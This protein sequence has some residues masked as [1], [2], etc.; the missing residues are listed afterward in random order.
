MP[1]YR[2]VLRSLLSHNSIECLGFRTDIAEIMRSCDALVL[3]SLSEGSALVCYEAR[4]CGLVLL[5]S[6]ACGAPCV[7]DVDGLVHSPGDVAA[8]SEH[9]RRLANPS[10]LYRLRSA[11][12]SGLQSITW[13]HAAQR[14]EQ[15]YHDVSQRPVPPPVQASYPGYRA[16]AKAIVRAP[17]ITESQFRLDR[18]RRRL[19]G[20]GLQRQVFSIGIFEGSSLLSLVAASGVENPVI[21]PEMVSD[22]DAGLVADPFW[23][24]HRHRWWMFFEVWNNHARKGEIACA[25]STDLREWHYLG[26]VLRDWCHLS[27]PYVFEDSG[28]IFMVP[29]SGMAGEIRLYRATDFPRRWR[30]QKVLLRGPYFDAT[31][32]R[33]DELWWMWAMSQT[34]SQDSG[35]HLFSS[36]ELE[37]GWQRHARNPIVQ[38]DLDRLRPAGRVVRDEERIVRFAQVSQPVYG[39][40]V[41]A[42]EI[43]E[44]SPDRYAE[45]EISTGPILMG[46]GVSWNQGGMHHLDA[47]RTEDGRWIGCVDGWRSGAH[48][49]PAAPAV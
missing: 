7:H 12:L 43:T 21:R 16:V 13:G 14:L 24:R 27:Y 19:R 3:P 28:Q 41:R 22:L 37:G 5:V 6:D 46:S 34:S 47:N 23:I 26:R 10:E 48:A 4:G 15:I 17:I 32:F 29:E 30:L 31:L 8:L 45:T 11:S 18:W 39:S 35:L 25:E 2:E 33:D 49:P 9:F 40:A 1:E 20:P 42:F 36:K 44:L 38:N